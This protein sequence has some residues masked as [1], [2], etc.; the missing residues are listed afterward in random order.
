MCGSPSRT[1][2]SEPG[3]AVGGR[4]P[5]SKPIRQQIQRVTRD[6]STRGHRSPKG[7]KTDQQHDSSLRARGRKP[8]PPAAGLGAQARSPRPVLDDVDRAFWV[9]LRASWPGWA[10]RLLLVHPDAVARWRRERFRRHW[11]QISRRRRPGRP[12]IEREV[13]DLIRLMAQDGWGAP[14][15]HGELLKLGFE[16]SQSTVSRYTPRRPVEPDKLKRWLAFLRNHKDALSAMDFFTVR[17]PRCAFSTSCSSSNTED[18]AS[19]TSTSPSIQ[20]RHR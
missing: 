7:L 12:R 17:P 14:R 4:C 2:V 1:T 20:P 6:Q 11:A 16:V 3:A 13:R 5:S 9:A 18:V 8:G 19:A 10:S 15:L